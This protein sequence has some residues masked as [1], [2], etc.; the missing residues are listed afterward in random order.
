MIE[1]EFLDEE[2]QRLGS[3]LKN[4]RSHLT[5]P[6][7]ELETEEEKEEYRKEHPELDDVM[8]IIEWIDENNVKVKEDSQY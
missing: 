8:E 5:K 7:I 2:E 6:Y 3:A 1:E 4:I